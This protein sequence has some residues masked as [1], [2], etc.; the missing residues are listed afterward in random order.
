[1][2]GRVP[3]PHLAAAAKPS[4][5]RGCGAPLPDLHRLRAFVVLAEELDVCRAAARLNLTAPSMQRVVKKLQDEL[6]A[7]LFRRARGRIEL[8]ADGEHLLP[9]ARALLDAA[10]RLVPDLHRAPSMQRVPKP[11]D[12]ELSRRRAERHSA[13]PP[14]PPRK[15]PA[16]GP[17]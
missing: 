11:A 13:E 1:M 16:P 2:I 12:D 14:P 5:A 6:Q 10:E 3:R 8:A 4:D 15:R 9:A 7:V 17:S